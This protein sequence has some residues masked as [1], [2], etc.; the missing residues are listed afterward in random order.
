MYLATVDWATGWPSLSSS[1]WSLD[2]FQGILAAHPAGQAAYLNR[3]FGPTTM[4]PRLPL[5]ISSESA[6]CHRTIVSTWTM[7]AVLDSDGTKRYSQ[8]KVG[9]SVAVSRD[10]A[11]TWRHNTF[12]WCRR[13]EDNLGVQPR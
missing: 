8:T 10:L 1:S 7:T 3:D 13:K 5:P 6:R 12:S 2:A 11:S 9:R 4:R